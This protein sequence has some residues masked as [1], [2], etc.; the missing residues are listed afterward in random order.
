MLIDK[1]K[2]FGERHTASNAIAWMLLKSFDVPLA[3]FDYLGWKHR[4]AP[5]PAE[6]KKYPVSSTLFVITA[7]N[8][9]TW[10]KAMHRRPYTPHQ[11]DLPTLAFRNFL[12]F[13]LEDYENVIQMWNEK[14]AGYLNF[15]DSVPNA[16][17][18][19]IEDFSTAQ[20]QVYEQIERIGLV[21]EFQEFTG[22][23]DGMALNQAP[24]AE[25][26]EREVLT[27]PQIPDEVVSLI[28]DEL[29]YDIMTKLGYMKVG[30]CDGASKVDFVSP[31]GLPN[32][33]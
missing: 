13:P 10:L 28:N 1:I 6:W 26:I 15:I 18:I 16:T 5:Q 32:S 33:N 12:K 20:K 8:P 4:R 29:D 31:A 14:N 27:L 11:P 24:Q 30:Q 17:L 3:G 7:R 19:R 22:Y 21:G 23:S 9:Y 25:K 2:V